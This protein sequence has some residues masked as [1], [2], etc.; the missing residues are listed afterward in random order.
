MDNIH[1]NTHLF[2]KATMLYISCR[3]IKGYMDKKQN[4]P[5]TG[6][7]NASSEETVSEGILIF[8]KL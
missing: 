8:N 2:V 6:G 1:I 5:D 7:K 4:I 3:A